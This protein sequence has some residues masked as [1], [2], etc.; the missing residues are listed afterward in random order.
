VRNIILFFFLIATIETVMA[1]SSLEE[2]R[3]AHSS[4]FHVYFPERTDVRAGYL[5]EPGARESNGPG[6]FDLHNSFLQ[7]S[8]V[9]PKSKDTFFSLGGDFEVRRYLF[10][11]VDGISTRAGSQNFYKVAFSPGIGAFL[12][13]KIL[14]WGSLTFGNYSDFQGGIF[15]WGDYQLLGQAKL[16]FQINPGAQVLFGVSYTN[17]YLDQ[18]FLPFVGIRL[19]SESGKLHISADLP[20]HG[21]VGYYVTPHIEVFGQI[22]IT[23][24]RFEGRVGD[25]DLTLGV[26]DERL[27]GGVRFWLGSY[28]SLTL[29][30]GRTLNNELRFITLNPGQFTPKGDVDMHTYFRTYLGFAF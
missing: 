11:V 8:T 30:A 16:I 19:L 10:E 7:F 25:Q 9:I 24:D 20:F 14:A 22:V 18:R 23:G 17:T 4:F 6:E 3:K 12:T 26:H 21:R 5:H 15:N 13:D 29:E 28:V 2:F 27:G 1:E